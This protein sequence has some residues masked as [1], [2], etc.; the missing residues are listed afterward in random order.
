MDSWV[1]TQVYETGNMCSLH[2]ANPLHFYPYS[3]WLKLMC[4]LTTWE[5]YKLA[6]V[7]SLY[8]VNASTFDYIYSL[9]TKTKSMFMKTINNKLLNIVEARKTNLWMHCRTHFYTCIYYKHIYFIIKTWCNRF[10]LL[11]I[12]KFN[13]MRELS[14]QDMEARYI[15]HDVV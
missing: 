3:Q 9:K 8:F 11:Y 6:I 7:N 12:C 13:G 15:E 4:K 2:R 10:R 5:H 14:P 1:V